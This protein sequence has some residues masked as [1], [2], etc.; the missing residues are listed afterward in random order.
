[1][2]K[3]EDTHISLVMRVDPAIAKELLA[4]TMLQ[5]TLSQHAVTRFARDMREGNWNPLIG[6]PL[7]LDVDTGGVLDGQHRLRAV[8]VQPDTFQIEF[9]V[10]KTHRRWIEV[11]DT[12]RPRSLKDTLQILGHRNSEATY[13]QAFLNTACRWATGSSSGALM[14][15]HEQIEWLRNNPNADKAVRF[16]QSI[17]DTGKRQK[18]ARV[19]AG[20]AATLFDI[21]EYGHGGDTVEQFIREIQFG[22]GDVGSP[23]QRLT[24]MMVRLAN[25]GTKESISQANLGYMISRVYQAWLNDDA[26][27][28]IHAR[29]RAVTA[30]PGFGE[31]MEANWPSTQ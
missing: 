14:T 19:P 7:V 26:L 5:R 16:A 9:P 6:S 2:K 21:A 4:K 18:V 24:V 11:I 12:G 27:G 15:R 1:M 3:S 17:T 23:S 31:W 29:R 13:M 22:S 20:I 28:K 8:T 25:K 10:V 30:L